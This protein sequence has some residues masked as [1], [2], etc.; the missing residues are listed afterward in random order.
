MRL[1]FARGLIALVILWNLQ[2]AVV[3]LLW[4]DRY[5]TDYELFGIPGAAALRGIG[6]LFVMWNVPYAVA[7]WHPVRHKLSLYEALV[8][9]AI[10]LAGE[11][12]IYSTL[13]ITF[14][15]LRG[16]IFRFIIFDALGLVLL[17]TSIW[18]T[19]ESST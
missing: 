3:F 18:I 10:G 13:P 15:I 16:S 1:N 12:M 5:T 9:Q 17:L 7:L 14:I 6:L 8:M 19:R 4:P 2:A 11:V